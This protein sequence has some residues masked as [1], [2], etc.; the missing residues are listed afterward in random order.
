V[1]WCLEHDAKVFATVCY[2]RP[3][4]ISAGR[5]RVQFVEHPSQDYAAQQIVKKFISMSVMDL[6]TIKATTKHELLFIQPGNT[7]GGSIT[8]QLTSCL[9]CL[10]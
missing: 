7:K 9:T 3:S 2:F 4:S 8:V 10:D 6:D 5:I 1:L